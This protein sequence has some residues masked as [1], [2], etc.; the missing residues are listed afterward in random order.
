MKPFPTLDPVMMRY[1]SDMS[2]MIAEQT[3]KH[4]F[5]FVDATRGLFAGT[6]QA[7][8]QVFSE[9]RSAP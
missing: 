4:G 8:C 1:R 5:Q 2:R 3:A 7:P 9:R 6:D